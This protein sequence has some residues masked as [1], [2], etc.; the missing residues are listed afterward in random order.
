MSSLL[1]TAA[2]GIMKVASNAPAFADVEEI[3]QGVTTA[4]QRIY[5]AFNNIVLPIILTALLVFA[6]VMGIIKGIKLAKAESADQ[7]QEAKKS[8]IT[9]LIGI[10]SAI[11][12]VALVMILM[13]TMANWLGVDLSGITG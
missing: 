9:F 6:V 13:P 2:D 3:E 5:Q 1:F 10:G 7:Q 11:L 4:A 12:V 8:L